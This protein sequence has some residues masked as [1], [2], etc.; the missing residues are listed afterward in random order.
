MSTTRDLTKQQYLSALSRHGLKMAGFM[1]YVEF[2]GGLSVCS[3]NG[4]RTYRAR[5]AY[6]LKRL[7]E[8]TARIATEANRG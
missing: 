7:D 8:E 1:G 6:L 4:G 2:P 5:L 3:L